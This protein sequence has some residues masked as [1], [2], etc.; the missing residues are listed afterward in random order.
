[1]QILVDLV[2][3]VD[4]TAM[5]EILVGVIDLMTMMVMTAIT[6]VPGWSS[7]LQ[8]YPTRLMEQGGYRL[9]KMEFVFSI[10]LLILGCIR[11]AKTPAHFALSVK[12]SGYARDIP[13]NSIDLHTPFTVCP[14]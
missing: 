5:V 3:Q 9:E 12:T 14:I 6:L 8:G 13:G 1:M 10:Y 7:F 4:L 2:D 11:L